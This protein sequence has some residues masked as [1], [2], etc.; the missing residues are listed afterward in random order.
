MKLKKK[1]LES[2]SPIL[3]RQ[4]K[5]NSWICLE[6]SRLKLAFRFLSMTKLSDL[7]NEVCSTSAAEKIDVP[8]SRTLCKERILI[9][10]FKI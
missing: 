5:M 3:I 1:Y 9:L 6:G 2:D 4:E 8:N 7:L 10:T